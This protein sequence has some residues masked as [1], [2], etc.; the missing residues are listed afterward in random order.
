VQLL[1]TLLK[2][3]CGFACGSDALFGRFKPT[4]T[5]L[6]FQAGK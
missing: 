2:D 4:P 1:E 6:F 3:I 5:Q